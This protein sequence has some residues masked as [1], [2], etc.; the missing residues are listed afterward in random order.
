MN[1]LK[2]TIRMVNYIV[3]SEGLH[4]LTCVHPHSCFTN[5][6]YNGLFR[7]V[8]IPKKDAAKNNINILAVCHELGHAIL[9]ER[10]EAP[11]DPCDLNPYQAYVVETMAWRIGFRLYRQ[12]IGLP[13]PNRS[14]KKFKE[15]LQSYKV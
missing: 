11:V 4:P 2:Y 6:G 7:A 10:G 9:I 1:N 8:C 15:G 14:W 3:Q 5:Y 13:I 12:Y